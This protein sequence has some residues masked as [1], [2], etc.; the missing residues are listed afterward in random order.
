GWPAN[1]VDLDRLVV[2]GI[3]D[4]RAAI[5]SIGGLRIP[6]GAGPRPA[7][8]VKEL[9]ALDPELT[10]LSEASEDLEPA[11][12]VK[13][14][15]IVKPR[16]AELGK[17]AEA[18][19]LSDCLTHDERFFVPDAVRAPVFAEQF[20]RLNRSVLKRLRSARLPAAATLGEI[21][22][23]FKRISTT[24]G[25]A[26]AGMDRL[27][28]PQWAAAQT[29]R[30]QDSL[31]ELQSAVQE[32]ENL[33]AKDKGMAPASREYAQYVR[34]EKELQRAANA[35]GKAYRKLLRR[36]GASPTFRV[37]PGDDG[38]ATEPES[39]DPA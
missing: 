31:L 39:G 9:K 24:L 13:V 34:R 29:S 38:G 37:P 8:F 17:R 35:E 15:E 14:A 11:D 25:R 7:A 21:D 22:T 23:A 1:L 12:F 2:R 6:E 19:G 10:K 4:A 36:V 16:L 20:A 3:D 26:V 18:A 30:Y 5:E 32:Y 28:P 27:D 33:L